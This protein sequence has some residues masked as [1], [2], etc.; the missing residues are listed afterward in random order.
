MT[1]G[2]GTAYRAMAKGGRA[3]LNAGAKGLGSAAPAAV[4]A[5]SRGTA[6][7]VGEASEQAFKEIAWKGP[8]ELAEQGGASLAKGAK[9]FGNLSRAETYG[10]QPYGRLRAA[11]KGTG[12]QSH[13][14]IEKRF[15]LV[16]NQKPSQM[17]S[18]AV[19]RAEH[20]VFTNAWR[21]AIPYGIGTAT[22]TKESI[23][24]AARS[25]YADYPA[26]LSALGL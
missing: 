3:A 15:A 8:R 18:M 23:L 7:A 22:A 20:Q 21:T 13:H 10:I 24:N 26:I 17:A 12:L 25:I 14:L 5:G 6:Q 19:T 4:T 2:A 16:L 11:I 1:A 9:A